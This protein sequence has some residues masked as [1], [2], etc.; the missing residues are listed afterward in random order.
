MIGMNR[1][2][3][4]GGAGAHLLLGRVLDGVGKLV[5]RISHLRSGNVCGGV[6]ESLG[7]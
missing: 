2:S 3:V 6:L 5:E 1:L 7:A 4:Y